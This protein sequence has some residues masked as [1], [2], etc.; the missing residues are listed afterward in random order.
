MMANLNSQMI[1]YRRLAKPEL[2][3]IQEGVLVLKADTRYPA[4]QA[5]IRSGDVIVSCNGR[6]VRTATDI[7]RALGFDTEKSVT[8]GI[9]RDQNEA[10]NVSFKPSSEMPKYSMWK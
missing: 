5:G 1:L 7:F 10:L 3:S 8:L 6:P 4:H 9:V 2:S